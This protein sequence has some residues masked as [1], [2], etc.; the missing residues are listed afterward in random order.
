MPPA[1]RQ[2]TAP[3]PAY[4]PRTHAALAAGRLAKGLSQALGKGEGQVIGGNVALLLQP[5]LLEILAAG[6]PDR[7][8]LGDQRQEHDHAVPRG[9][10]WATPDRSPTTTAAPTW[11]TAWSRRSTRRERRRRAALEVDEAYLGPITAAVPPGLDHA[12]EPQLTSSRAASATSARRATG[13]R[14]STASAGLHHRRQRRRPARRVDRA[15]GDATSSGSPAASSWKRGRAASAAAASCRCGGRASGYR[16]ERLRADARPSRR[17]GSR[18]ASIA[19][20]PRQRPRRHPPAGARQPVN[21]LFAVATAALYGVDG[22]DGDDR[23][24]RASARSTAATAH[25]RA[26]TAA[27]SGCTW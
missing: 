8:R 3:H 24:G 22:R 5:R 6:P 1:S 16:C 13:A 15:A 7:A 17:G 20:P 21:A 27:P 12:H 18:T 10:A 4:S 19:R 26:S 9:R 2:T 25:L 11:P 14:P 23:D